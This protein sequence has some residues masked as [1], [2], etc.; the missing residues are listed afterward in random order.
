MLI[1]SFAKLGKQ[2]QECHELVS[3]VFC[4]F[5]TNLVPYHGF[6]NI[7][8]PFTLTAFTLTLSRFPSI[9]Q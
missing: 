4:F 3:G 7:Y 6:L 8:N 1:S 9:V 2:A 5:L